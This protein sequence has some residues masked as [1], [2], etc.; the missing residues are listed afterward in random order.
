MRAVAALVA[1]DLKGVRRSRSQL[2]SSILFPLMLLAILGSGVEDGLD[3]RRIADYTTFLTPGIIVM[4]ALFSSTFSSASYYQDRDSGILKVFLASPHS[5]RV[6]LLGKTLSS[7]VIGVVQAL[8]VLTVAA[9]IP[10]I[11]FH[12]QYGVAGSLAV[13]VVAIV[14]LNL[15]LSGLGQFLASR[16]GTMQGF[17]LLMMLA[18]FPFLFLSGAFFPLQHLPEWLKILGRINPLAYGVDMMHL[19]LYSDG[20]GGYFGLPIDLVVMGVLAVGVF[21]IGTNRSVSPDR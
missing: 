19:A 13:A 6:I 1:R 18:L 7:V 14:L 5:Q 9:L 3:P 10:A 21:Y 20:S 15:F 11:N 17:H 4:T 16:I 2:Y 8:F 12:W